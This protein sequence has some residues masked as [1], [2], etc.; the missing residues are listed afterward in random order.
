MDNCDVACLVYDANDQYSF[1]NLGTVQK[2]LPNTLP[3]MFVASKLDLEE[4]EQQFDVTPEEFCD[5]LQLVRPRRISVAGTDEPD[6][7]PVTEVWKELVLAAVN[8]ELALPEWDETDSDSDSDDEPIV[9]KK[10]VILK[11]VVRIG[12]AVGVASLIGYAI[13]RFGFKKN[14]KK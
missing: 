8:P 7:L 2:D 5:R 10:N 6:V 3:R 4:V 12:L 14:E 11:R 9:E 1:L 13:Y